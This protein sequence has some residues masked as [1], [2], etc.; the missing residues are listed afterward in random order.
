VDESAFDGVE[1]ESLLDSVEIRLAPE[2]AC[3]VLVVD[4]LNV[5]RDVL[6]H[7][8]EGAGFATLQ[9]A[10][11]REAIETM[12]ARDDVAIVLMDIRM[13]VLNGIDATKE[14]RA[15]PAIAK[16]PVL[17][18]SAS[19]FPNLGARAQEAGFDD[20]VGKPFRAGEVF[21]K[22]ENLIGVR[23]V[24]AGEDVAEAAEETAAAAPTAASGE[25]A[26]D[27]EFAADAA[28]RLREAVEMG[29]VDALS[30]V[31]GE[32][33]SQGSA[34]VAKELEELVFAFDFD[35]VGRMADR[36]GQGAVDA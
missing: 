25:G 21:R 3:T 4:D 14:I 13:P 36:L 18:I 19:V 31:A 2:S 1:Q 26:L 5:N 24:R 23:Y 29:D 22:I 11:G 10:D 20:F 32:M 30:A 6:V 16:T 28:R 7:L 17:A 27:A 33:R 15:T 12:K 35:G 9:A 34:G 8:L